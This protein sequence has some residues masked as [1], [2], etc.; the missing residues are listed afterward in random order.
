MQFRVNEV[1]LLILK[2]PI[3]NAIAMAPNGVVVIGWFGF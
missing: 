2:G 3:R 1:N